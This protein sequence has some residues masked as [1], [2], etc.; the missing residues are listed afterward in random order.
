M[1]QNRWLT[2][3]VVS[4]LSSLTL[5]MWMRQ[6]PLCINSK[7]VKKIDIQTSEVL[8]GG[9]S[10]N[11][12]N[13]SWIKA[14]N[15]NAKSAEAYSCSLEQNVVYNDELRILIEK[16]T[17][18]LKLVEDFFGSNIHPIE[19]AWR[20]SMETDVAKRSWRQ[21]KIQGDK[22]IYSG[23]ADLENSSNAVSE[24]FLDSVLAVQLQ[25]PGSPVQENRTA[26]ALAQAYLDVLKF[27]LGLSSQSLDFKVDQWSLNQSSW[28]AYCSSR[29]ISVLDYS[30]CGKSAAAAYL[31]PMNLRPFFRE[32]FKQALLALPLSKQQETLKQL[33]QLFISWTQGNELP[34]SS[35]KSIAI[36]EIHKTTSL[37]LK[38]VEAW[39]EFYSELRRAFEQRGWAPENSETVF[40]KMVYF[41]QKEDQE[42]KDISAFLVQNPNLRDQLVA[43]Q[44]GTWLWMPHL[45]APIEVAS[46]GSYR[47]YNMVVVSCENP[48]LSFLAKLSEI[49]EH[50]LFVRDCDSRQPIKL[51]SYFKS[52]IDYFAVENE[53][54]DFVRFHMPS[55]RLALKSEK[56]NPFELVAKSKWNAPYFSRIGW[57][58]PNWQKKSHYFKANSAIEVIDS[59]RIDLKDSDLKDGEL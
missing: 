10:S 20:K 28:S 33:A 2:L 4:L 52:G 25:I 36:D 47:V 31:E 14:K 54:V 32:S 35:M 50:V 29:E 9:S 26:L 8:S 59:Y 56:A 17:P 57:Q 30:A 43:I 40:Q 45:Y 19:W 37:F 51:E 27:S 46:I 23:P 38:K 24:V 53:K 7:L 12:K 55:F 6:S 11:T 18:S 13:E 48:T 41:P 39:P 22:I 3:L 58:K 21:W 34:H 44:T 42:K 16:I 15:V 49:T 1:T 5:F